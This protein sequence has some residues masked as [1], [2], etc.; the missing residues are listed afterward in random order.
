LDWQACYPHSVHDPNAFLTVLALVLGVAAVTTVLFQ[1]LRHPVVLGYIMAG[2]II[3]P[4]IPIPLLA[5]SETVHTLSEL[6]V[7]LMAARPWS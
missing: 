7:M 5:D 3:G 6:S 2:L 1:R 4:H